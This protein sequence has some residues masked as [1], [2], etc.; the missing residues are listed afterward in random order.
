MPHLRA[1]HVSFNQLMGPLP[2]AWRAPALQQ[3]GARANMLAGPLPAKL[4]SLPA[5]SVL[6]L[7]ARRA[8]WGVVQ[9]AGGYAGRSAAVARRTL[10]DTLPA[11]LASL[12]ALSVLGWR[13]HVRPR[14]AS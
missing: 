3:L 5:L 1:L 12:S 10:A 8:V 4:A 6:D 9:G 7:Q 11:K 14:R 2:A 13:M